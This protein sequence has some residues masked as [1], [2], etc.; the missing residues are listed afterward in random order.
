M[1][2]MSSPSKIRASKY[3][4]VYFS[5]ILF[6]ISFGL[7]ILVGQLF[8]VDKTPAGEDKKIDIKNV[9]NL[10]RDTNRSDSVDFNQFWEVWDRVKS[11]YVKQPVKDADLFYGAIQ[12]LVLALGDP[13][14]VY[15]PPAAA[16]EFSKD[17]S[18]ELEGIGAEIG[19]KNNELTVIAPLPE[20]PAERA[21]LRPADRILMIDKEM[22]AGMDI[23]TAISKIRGKGGTP[24][25]LTVAR[26]GADKTLEITIIRAKIIV[27]SVMY[28]TKPGN[29]AYIRVMQFNDETTGIFSKYIKRLKSENAKGIVLDLRGNPGGYLDAS[30][31]MASEWIKEGVIVSERGLEGVS[32]EHNTAGSHRLV[33]IKTIVLVNQGSASASEIV[34]GALQDHKQATVIG[35]KTYGK[36]SVQDYETFTDGS[37]LKLTVAEWYTPNGKNINKEGIT[38]DIEV[39]EDFEHDKVGEDP[40]L[41]KALE[42]LK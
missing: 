42:L 25:T 19:I 33:G 12:G 7:G 36:G 22:T 16:T 6:V 39:K 29:I 34:A 18:G 13:Y 15:M 35:E 38:P 24:V 3:F 8:L 41:L 11:K 28:F 5:V 1:Y 21:G 26:D 40:V 37:A 9:I 2:Q 10:N 17:L 4:G 20:T 14:S 32:K 23:N 31:E 27:P 30:I